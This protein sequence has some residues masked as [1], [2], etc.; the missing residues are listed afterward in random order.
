MITSFQIYW[1][2][3]KFEDGTGSKVRPVTI[4]Q[5]GDK[6]E[7]F[8]IVGIYSYRKWF[9]QDNRFYEIIDWRE[10]GLEK[11]SYIKLSLIDEASKNFLTEDNYIGNLTER[12]I[13]GLLTAIEKYYS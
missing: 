10:A 1:Y 5:E 6:K 7:V 4:L 2:K 12:D 8:E 9:S 3:A 11:E 13:D